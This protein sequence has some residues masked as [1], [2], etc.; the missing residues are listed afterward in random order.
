MTAQRQHAVH[1]PLHR[2]G[3]VLRLHHHRPPAERHDAEVVR[4]RNATAAAVT[5]L[6]ANGLPPIDPLRS[7]SRHSAVPR[8]HPPPDPQSLRI[9]ATPL[10]PAIRRWLRCWRRRRDRRRRR[11]TARRRCGP[12]PPPRRTT[13]RHVEHEPGGEPPRQLP[14]PLHPSPAS[15]QPATPSPHRDRPRARRR[16]PTRR[17]HRHTATPR[18][19]WVGGRGRRRD[20]VAPLRIFDGGRR[21]RPLLQAAEGPRRGRRFSRRRLLTVRPGAAVAEHLV[22]EHRD[23]LLGGVLGA[24]AQPDP[25]GQRDEHGV[26]TDGGAR[27]RLTSQ[28]RQTTPQRRSRRSRRAPTSRR[29]APDDHGCGGPPRR[30]A[31]PTTGRRSRHDPLHDRDLLGG[32]D[33]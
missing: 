24:L 18:S 9:H 13:S 32:A 8:L 7:T 4:R 19:N 27:R 29:A 23:D 3:D 20:V 14:Q 5:A 30:P 31:R 12:S 16:T 10:P 21:P 2:R 15:C 17:A 25:P 1:D 28:R 22:P 11:R 26:E 33:W 6:V